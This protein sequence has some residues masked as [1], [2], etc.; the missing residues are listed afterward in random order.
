[1]AGIPLVRCCDWDAT[2]I[3]LV[4]LTGFESL[5]SGTGLQHADSSARRLA[6]GND[7]QTDVQTKAKDPG[8][9]RG[10]FLSLKMIGTSGLQPRIRA[11]APLVGL[12]PPPVVLLA[13]T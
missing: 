3:I 1:M 9:Q 4:V 5:H 7:Q 8:R 12:G 10:N 6:P 2:A 13:F 11:G